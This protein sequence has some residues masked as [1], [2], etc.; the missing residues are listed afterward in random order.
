MIG[1]GG[2]DSLNGDRGRPMPGPMPVGKPP[3]AGG[4]KPFTGGPPSP[5]SGPVSAP[6]TAAPAS[7]MPYGQ[8]HDPAGYGAPRAPG[9]SPLGM[10]QSWLNTMG[11]YLAQQPTSEPMAESGGLSSLAP[12]TSAPGTMHGYSGPDTPWQGN[13]GFRLLNMQ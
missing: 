10:W 4:G 1:M 8:S 13:R 6:K 7:S 2:F 11:P 5:S 12:S 9:S 3:M